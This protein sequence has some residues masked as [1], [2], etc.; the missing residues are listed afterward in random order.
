MSGVFNSLRSLDVYPKLSEE[1]KVRT[2]SGAAS[3]IVCEI[4]FLI[5]CASINCCDYFHGNFVYFGIV[6]LF[7]D[8]AD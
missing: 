4:L 1:Y 2:A 6:V 7:D 3:K 5:I 8:S